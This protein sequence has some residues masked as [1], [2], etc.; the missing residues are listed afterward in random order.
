MRNLPRVLGPLLVLAACG[1][2]A[3]QP[4]AAQTPA[5]PTANAPA[6]APD[7]GAPVASAPEQLAWVVATINAGKKL[8]PAAVNERF[9]PSFLGEIP[10]DKLIQLFA[11][12]NKQLAPL[13]KIAVEGEGKRRVGHFKSAAGPMQVILEVDP[14]SGKMTTLLVRPDADAAKMPETWEGVEKQLAGSGKRSQLLVASLKRDKCKPIR[15]VRADQSMA[16]GSAF[17]LYVL[18]ALAQRIRAGAL[19]WDTEI[20]IR[21]DWKSLPSGTTQTLPAGTKRTVRQLAEKMISISDNTAADHLLRTVGRKRVEKGLRGA[22]HSAPKKNIPFLATRELFAL[23]LALSAEERAAYLKMKPEARRHALEKIATRKVKLADAA[24]WKTPKS[25]DLEWF[26]SAE[27]LCRVMAGLR[28]LAAR[29]KK[30]TPLLEVL[31]KNPGLTIDEKAF[32]YVGF[33][34]GSEPGVMTLAFLV[35]DA[36][37]DWY[38]VVTQVND[39]DKTLDKL[40]IMGATQAAFKL[41]AQD[42][43]EAKK[44]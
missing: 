41:L 37:K 20:A 5:A 23:K 1:P 39:P 17:K 40:S 2:D 35:R 7:A 13:E 28:H 26:A 44:K 14:K 25:L 42:I 16:I 24:D 21:D 15:A 30:L 10:A 12:I 27:D 9:A 4:P 18:Y 19:S 22:G 34:G 38:V 3:A 32:P 36:A 8:D 43:A 11:G 6:P 29:N 33:K 31:S